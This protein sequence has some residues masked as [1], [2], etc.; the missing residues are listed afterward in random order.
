[1]LNL[2]NSM[3]LFSRIK[4]ILETEHMCTVSRNKEPLYVVMR[5]D[6][7]QR[8]TKVA[9]DNT[10]A[11]ELIDAEQQDGEYD[12]DINKIPV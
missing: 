3:T 2:F 10:R 9:D 6:A 5:W 1:M 12:I 7:Y 4:K 8:V 11:K